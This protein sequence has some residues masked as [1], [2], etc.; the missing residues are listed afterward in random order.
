MKCNC[1]FIAGNSQWRQYDVRTDVRAIDGG[2]AGF[3]CDVAELVV[4]EDR[5]ASFSEVL[6]TR[7]GWQVVVE[8]MQYDGFGMGV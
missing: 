5:H 8:R 6:L 4:G 1:A 3:Y 2:S 7:Y